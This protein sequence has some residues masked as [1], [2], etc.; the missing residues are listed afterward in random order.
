MDTQRARILAAHFFVAKN[1]KKNTAKTV[2]FI[3]TNRD[4]FPNITDECLNDI[5][6]ENGVTKEELEQSKVRKFAGINTEK[7][8]F[9]K[10]DE[11]D[12]D[13]HKKRPYDYDKRDHGKGYKVKPSENDYKST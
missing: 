10:Q 12:K 5:I 2:K 9:E 4:Y 6:K 7:E 3:Q 11:G 8:A 1:L 13:I